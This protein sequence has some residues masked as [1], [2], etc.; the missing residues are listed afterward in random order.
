MRV[1]VHCGDDTRYIMLSPDVRFSEFIERVREKLGLTKGFKVKVRDEGD[2]ITMGD[3][4][5]WEMAIQAVRKEARG[6]DVDMGKME[7]WVC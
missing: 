4:D 1:K 5:D 2:L 7:I 6:E 3:G